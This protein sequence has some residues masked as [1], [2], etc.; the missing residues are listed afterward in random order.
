MHLTTFSDYSMRVLMYLA[1]Q[2]E[3]RVT[4][5]DIA[6]RY[7]ISD[8]HLTKVVH[9][10]A[11]AGYVRTI[12]GKGGGLKLNSS[13]EAI[14]LGEVLRRTEGDEGLLPCVNGEGDCCLIPVCRLTGILRES[15]QAMYQVL[16]KYTLADLLV[17]K[18]PLRQ[19]LIPK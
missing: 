8:N 4:I 14:N 11:R 12:R 7:Q 6:Q 9:F 13:V 2:Q 10:L 18:A 16:D 1:L 5:A 3:Q 17:D 15:Q 19:V